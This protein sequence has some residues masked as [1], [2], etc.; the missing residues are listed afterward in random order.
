MSGLRLTHRDFEPAK[1]SREFTESKIEFVETAQLGGTTYVDV[2]SIGT[3]ES[4]LARFNAGQIAFESIVLSR[5]T[6]LV[7]LDRSDIGEVY[8]ATAPGPASEGRHSE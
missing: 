4:G 7:G 3:D 8:I 5:G 6:G 2:L 1:Q